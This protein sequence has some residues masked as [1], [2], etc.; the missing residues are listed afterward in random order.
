MSDFKRFDRVKYI[1]AHALGW[2]DHED[3]EYGTVSSSGDT[4]LVFVKF[5]NDIYGTEWL[6]A[7]SKGCERSSLKLIAR[8]ESYSELLELII[9]ELG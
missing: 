5:D 1:P 7:Q 6:D 4:G 8:D 9:G 3:C 2:E